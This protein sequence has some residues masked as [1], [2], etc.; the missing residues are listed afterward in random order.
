[1]GK[2]SIRQLMLSLLASTA[3]TS[4]GVALE[5]SGSAV[6]VDRITNAS[7]PG[8]R[9]V[10]EAESDVF[11][12][13]A[14][15]T[16]ANGLAQIRFVDNTRIVIGPNSRLVVD[17]FVFN[18]D[19]TA[20]KVTVSAVKGVFRFIS[21]NSAHSAYKI[22]TPTM[23]IGVRGTALDINASAAGSSVVFLSGSGTACD[24]RAPAS[25]SP[26]SA[27]PL[28]RLPAVESPRRRARTRSKR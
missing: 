19:N 27:N 9:R 13:D 4:Q 18:P 1:L 2:A 24:N 11:M 10:L 22:R 6:K 3:I 12:G 15:V 20:R 26:T 25:T 16:N 17:S 14:I 21:G 7:G 8:G 5:A 23:T 28:S